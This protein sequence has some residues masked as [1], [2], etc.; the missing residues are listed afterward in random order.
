MTFDGQ[1]GTVGRVPSDETEK[2]EHPLDVL[3]VSVVRLRFGLGV[4]GVRHGRVMTTQRKESP[5]G[6]GRERRDSRGYRQAYD[7]WPGSH[8]VAG[9]SK[10]VFYR[11]QVR[12]GAVEC[13]LCKRQLAYPTDHLVAQ[14]VVDELTVETADAIECPVCSGLVFIKDGSPPE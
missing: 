14:G 9:M 7:R 8:A 6:T 10:N 5:G 2:V 3:P 1:P 13:P 11:D 12:A 4:V